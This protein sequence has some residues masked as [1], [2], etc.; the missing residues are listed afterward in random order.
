M[1]TRRE[2]NRRVKR[3]GRSNLVLYMVNTRDTRWPYRYQPCI[4]PFL[5]APHDHFCFPLQL[6]YVR[7][8]GSLLLPQCRFIRKCISIVPYQNLLSLYCAMICYWHMYRFIKSSH[9]RST[10]VH[11]CISHM[12][13]HMYIHVS[14]HIF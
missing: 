8:S 7:S 4:S 13:M 9:M 2:R 1:R 3:G 10:Y 12:C 5:N 11:M 6:R 14:Y